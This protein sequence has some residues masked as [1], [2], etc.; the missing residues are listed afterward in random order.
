MSCGRGAARAGSSAAQDVEVFMTA[1]NG[2]T[3]GRGIAT[4]DGFT[5]V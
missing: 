4:F 1:A 3:D 2:W 5:V